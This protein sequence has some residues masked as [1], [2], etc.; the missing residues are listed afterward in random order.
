MMTTISGLLLHADG[1]PAN[2]QAVISWIAFQIHE[3]VIV[4]GQKMVEII[5][6]QFTV[7]LYPNI[8]AHPKGAYYTVRMELDTGIVYEE[9][10]VV[11]DMPTASVEQVRSSFP[12][13]PGMLINP[14]Q[15]AG[16]GAEAGMILAYNGSY[17]VPGYVTVENVSP[18]WIQLDV[19]SAGDDFWIDGSP[20]QLG[21]IATINIPS[22][23]LTARGLVT[24]G[25]QSFAGNKTFAG[26][27]LVQGSISGP[28]ITD[29]YS[30]INGKV[31]VTRQIIAGDGMGGGGTLA[32]DVTLTADVITVN[33][34][35]GNVVISPGS[36]GGV[37]ATRQIIAGAGLGGGGS[38]AADV[39]LTANVLS[40]NGLTGAVVLTP[41]SL[42]VV[43][44]HAIQD[45][46]T[47]QTHRAALNF[48]GDG[49]SVTD[50]VAN[51]RSQITITG[52][53]AG[54][55]TPWLSDIDANTWKL[56]NAGGIAVGTAAPVN[57]TPAGSVSV[58]V[59][60]ST[61][62]GILELA[63]N[64]V[65]A[66]DKPIGQ[67]LFTDA[68]NSQTS[69]LL[70][71]INIIRNGIVAGN[72]GAY[73]TLYS[74][75][76]GGTGVVERM[77]INAS[78]NIAMGVAIDPGARLQV[79]AIPGGTSLICGD[80]TNSTLFIRHA[81][82]PVASSLVIEAGGTATFVFRNNGADRMLI[83]PSGDV[84]IGIGGAAGAAARLH[85]GADAFRQ[86][87]LTSSS[88]PV[89]KQMRLGYDT[90]N[91]TVVVEGFLTGVG[92]VLLLNPSGGNVCIGAGAAFASNK[93]TVVD[94]VADATGADATLANTIR[95][96]LMVQGNFTS[97][98]GACIQMGAGGGLGWH[99]KQ[100]CYNGNEGTLNFY[101][102][103]AAGS[104]MQK[105]LSLSVGSATVFGNMNITGVYQI[106]GTNIT[107][108][109]QSP[110]VTNH[111]AA[112]FTLHSVNSIA[113]GTADASGYLFQASAA[114][115]GAGQGSI[116]NIFNLAT[117]DPNYDQLQT[118]IHRIGVSGIWES[119]A[120][121]IR[122]VIDAVSVRSFVGF[123]N[124]GVQLAG[125][126]GIALLD[127]NTTSLTAYR[128]IVISSSATI[129]GV[130]HYAAGGIEV[131]SS[132]HPRIGF[133]WVGAVAA[134]IGMDSSAT[135]RTYDNPGTGYAPFRCAN[136]TASSFNG[137]AMQADVSY[138]TA[139][140][141]LR[142]GSNGVCYFSESYFQ[143]N[144]NITNNCAAATFNGLAIQGD[145]V[146]PGVNKIIR[147]SGLGYIFASYVNMVADRNTA[148]SLAT[149]IAMETDSAGY[150]RWG[151]PGDI[152]GYGSPPA[153]H[154]SICRYLSWGGYNPFAGYCVFDASS[155]LMPNG[156]ACN[157]LNPVYPYA[158]TYP[159]LMAFANGATHGV[160]VDSARISDSTS[161]AT[162]A[163]VANNVQ[164][165]PDSYF[166]NVH[167]P[168]LNFNASI[169]YYMD[170]AGP[171]NALRVFVAGYEIM[172]WSNYNH[173]T[174]ARR[175]RLYFLNNLLSGTYVNTPAARAAGLADGDVFVNTAGYVI[176]VIPG[177]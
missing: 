8:T 87:Y 154:V 170:C 177:T 156:G 57:P 41:A 79:N 161:F 163:G 141:V 136:I 140:Q 7:Q 101:G 29:I 31:P 94:T 1:E 165:N 91:N 62:W 174:P 78:G 113:I 119:A 125:A 15:I 14:M 82:T 115:L 3:V 51:N 25:D 65:D 96:G 26:N 130:M 73:M 145:G 162:V 50:D 134:Q 54:S 143:Q 106:S 13:E 77:R 127:V 5:D 55:Q 158:Q 112:N 138:P 68:I 146:I 4:G 24:T 59:A 69:K 128:R 49:V 111:N 144:A 84:S 135:V 133:H 126:G 142:S 2:G 108:A 37:P 172:G 129:A 36:I 10:W 66:N 102:A 32:A 167:T 116:K 45:E 42:G 22:A 39:T 44:G 176:C 117:T 48:V 95:R 150:L 21:R 105:V 61:G 120:W 70:G 121:Y 157:N 58:N 18:N 171:N 103:S 93:L 16:S 164:G 9:Y 152:N 131:Q 155:G 148:R 88:D 23:S 6:G 98:D 56:K 147:S 12:L 139:S 60:G 19:G 89:N 122:R 40:V 83:N 175:G 80:S 153:N 85:V 110:W 33:G 52:G 97:L 46:G 35:V 118:Y 38:L 169:Q 34:Q 43:Q 64:A 90:S 63:T 53:G 104:N 27:V 76:D 20:V 47:A 74:R 86:L 72:R 67:I 99:I 166:S 81:S 132:D 71:A 109:M 11:P 107:G 75:P 114:P 92:V 137:L 30:Q 159:T 124:D 100:A 168:S 17:W 151:T 149:A 173:P 123:M 160:R 28:T